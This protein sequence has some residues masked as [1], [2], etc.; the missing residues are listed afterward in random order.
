MRSREI[1]QQLL[2]GFKCVEG[3]ERVGLE[4]HHRAGRRQQVQTAT[5]GYKTFITKMKSEVTVEMS[6]VAVG[7]RRIPML[8]V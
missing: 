2:G 4:S 1:Q 6:S 8:D 7:V 5:Y 3:E